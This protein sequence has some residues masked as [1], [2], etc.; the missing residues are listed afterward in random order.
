MPQE[1]KIQLDRPRLLVVDDNEMNRDMLSRR[2]QRYG[3]ETEVACDGNDALA[4]L[5]SKD[6]DLVLLTPTEN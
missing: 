3:Y 6:F 5:I 2:L 1:P 4:Q